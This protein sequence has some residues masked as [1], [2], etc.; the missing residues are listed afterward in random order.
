MWEPPEWVEETDPTSGVNYYVRL[1]D[2][3]TPLHS[4]WSAPKSFARLLR[5]GAFNDNNIESDIIEEESERFVHM[6]DMLEDF[7]D[8]K[9]GDQ[10]YEIELESNRMYR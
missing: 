1:A 10:N 3:A 7:N 6:E 8:K 2:D 4:T 9:E 5:P